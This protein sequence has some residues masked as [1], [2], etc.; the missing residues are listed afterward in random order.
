MSASFDYFEHGADIGIVGMGDTLEEAFIGGA[1]ALFNV[2]VDIEG[3]KPILRVEISCAAFNIEE[4]FIEWLNTLIAEADMRDMVFREF[5]IDFLDEERLH[6]YALGERLDPKRH[7]LKSEV[8]AATY[9]MLSVESVDD[10][11]VAKC[12]VDV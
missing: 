7:S 9:S 3:V 1:L 8:K 10:L 11:F 5:E 6:G 2:M 12:V 4:L